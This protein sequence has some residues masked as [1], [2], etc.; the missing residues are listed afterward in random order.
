MK[1][2]LP[3]IV[4]IGIYNTDISQKNVTVSKKRKTTMFEIEIPLED[5]G[6][7]YI[8]TDEAPIRTNTIICVKPGQLRHTKLPF[9]CRYIH[10]IVT[11]GVLFDMLTTLPDFIKTEKTEIYTGLF[12][13]MEKLFESGIESDEIM[14]QSTLLELHPF[15]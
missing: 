14:L 7:S 3:E 12:K 11:E 1:I 13:T 6:V 10:M 9:K 8:N 4:A 5:G 2:I 15:W